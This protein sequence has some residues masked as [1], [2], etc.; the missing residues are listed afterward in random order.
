MQEFV[1]GEYIYVK[2]ETLKG[3]YQVTENIMYRGLKGESLIIIE[4]EDTYG[5]FNYERV[6]KPTDAEIK[7][8]KLKE[9]F[10]NKNYSHNHN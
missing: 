9:I 6:R 4:N 3:V 10:S 7:N 5:Y 2:S 1:V 8:Y